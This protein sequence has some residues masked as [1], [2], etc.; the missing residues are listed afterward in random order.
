MILPRVDDDGDEEM[1]I[2]KMEED[3]VSEDITDVKMAIVPSTTED[4]QDS[5]SVLTEI[6]PV[7]KS[8]TPSVSPITENNSSRKSLRTC[9]MLT[10][11]QKE[12]E[13]RVFKDLEN[14]LEN[15]FA[16][17]LNHNLAKSLH[18]GL[19][20]IDKNRKTSAYE[21]LSFKFCYKSL[22]SKPK[23]VRKDIGVQTLNEKKLEE[24]EEKVFLCR[25]CNCKSSKQVE[26]D[27]N[28]QLVPVD[29]D[30]SKQLVPKV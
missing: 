6:P 4:N 19:E 8:P 24:E 16:K 12:Q 18:R 25:N 29:D 7:L 17:K 26:E 3:K 20:V 2:V 10:A 15:H 9:T 28:L 5:L 27:G 1:E 22:D 13:T 14:Q 21:R 30:K 11:S 23:L